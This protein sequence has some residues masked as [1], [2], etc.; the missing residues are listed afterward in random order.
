MCRRL[1]SISRKT[2]LVIFYLGGGDVVAPVPLA[3]MLKLNVMTA[4]IGSGSASYIK[5]GE[6]NPFYSLLGLMEDIVLSNSRLIALQTSKPSADE[7]LTKHAG[8]IILNASRFVDIARFKPDVPY[9]ER[10]EVVG[11][12]GRLDRTKGI[13]EFVDAVR[14]VRTARNDVAFIIIGDGPQ[15]SSVKEAL[16]EQGMSKWVSVFGWVPHERIPRYLNQMRLLVLPSHMEGLPTVIV[17]SMACATPVLATPVGGVTDLIVE[18]ETGFL[19]ASISSS[20]ISRRILEILERPD[21]S[22][23]A[24]N[25]RDKVE[26]DFSFESAVRRWDKIIGE[27]IDSMRS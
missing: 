5:S 2:D 25:A 9:E 17:E 10:S 14:L 6:R 22:R 26:M 16:A 4:Y 24:L 1:V 23:I 20:E 21:A 12:I 7:N 27:A 8:K 13:M 3:K 19:L 11:Y 18:G 15:M